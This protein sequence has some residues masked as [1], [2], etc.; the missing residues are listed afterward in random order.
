VN[1]VS[2][3][4]LGLSDYLAG[5]VSDAAVVVQKTSIANLELVTCGSRPKNPSELLNA[6]HLAKL[7]AWARGRYHRVIVDCPPVFPVSDVLLWGKHVSSSIFIAR[8]GHTRVPLIR[9]ACARLRIG[10]VRIVGGVINGARTRTTRYAD[11]R[12][13]DLY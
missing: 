8:S 2:G 11:G 9:T 6:H 7:L 4:K 10:G 1:L 12:Y 5:G 13:A 3:V